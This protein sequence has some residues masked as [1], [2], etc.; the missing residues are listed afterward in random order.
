M[1]PILSSVGLQENLDNLGFAVIDLIAAGRIGDFL[2]LFDRHR[3]GLPTVNGFH[4][5]MEHSAEAVRTAVSQ[6]L[7]DMACNELNH[8]FVNFKIF[9]SSFIIKESGRDDNE[10]PLH[11]DW[12]FVDEDA[13]HRSYTVWVALTD[14][15][16]EMGT[17]GVISG[18]HRELKHVRYS[19][20]DRYAYRDR[21]LAHAEGRQLD[22]I[23]LKA[24]QALIW[25]HALIHASTPNR[26]GKERINLSFA[27]TDRDCGLR[28]CWLSPRTGLIEVFDVPDDFYGRNNSTT[29]Q[30]NY[31]NGTR[32]DGLTPVRSIAV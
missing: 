22:R 3:P 19:P 6:E 25:D 5:T 21:M 10:V 4:I 11:Q 20:N 16:H 31:L 15:T 7:I 23:E 26:S 14:I 12:T 13:G 1:T 27:M 32:P 24:G 28:H 8:A 9:Q 30:Q 29:L 18:S 17:V 2:A